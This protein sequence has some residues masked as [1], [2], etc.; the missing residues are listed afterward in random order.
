MMAGGGLG[1]QGAPAST[2]PQTQALTASQK[3]QQIVQQHGGLGGLLLNNSELAMLNKR[4]KSREQ[5][6]SHSRL[7]RQAAPN[8]SKQSKDGPHLVSQEEVYRRG[9]NVMHM[10][11]VV[12][13]VTQNSISFSSEQRPRKQSSLH[14]QSNS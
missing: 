9:H 1:R 10:P 6:E 3:Q 14:Q 4:Q 12:S 2:L 8:A 7:L 13:K 5:P 11:E